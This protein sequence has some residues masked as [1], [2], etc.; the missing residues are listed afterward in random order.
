MGT[1]KNLAGLENIYQWNR[2]IQA[3]VN[4]VQ[5]RSTTFLM[6]YSLQAVA[7]AIWYE[8][9]LRRV[10]EP[11]Q[12]AACVIARLDKLI[13]NRITSIRR[14]GNGKHEKAMSIWFGKS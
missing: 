4:G 5:G 10:G 6:R 8:R 12:P 13:R 1:V 3:V 9:N 11:S 14:R 2:L 7:Y